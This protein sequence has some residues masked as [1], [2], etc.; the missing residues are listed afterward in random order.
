MNIFKK[1]K[2]HRTNK[3]QEILISSLYDGDNF[4]ELA[5]IGAG[6]KKSGNTLEML[7][8]I[9]CYDDILKQQSDEEEQQKLDQKVSILKKIEE[10]EEAKNNRKILSLED[11]NFLEFHPIQKKQAFMDEINHEKTGMTKTKRLASVRIAETSYIMSISGENYRN[12]LFHVIKSELDFK[13]RMLMYL[14][15]FQVNL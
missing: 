13:I 15:F 14:P 10:L 7:E 1:V 9:K 11:E 3:T 6:K 5:M 2:D 12:I 8:N 4:G